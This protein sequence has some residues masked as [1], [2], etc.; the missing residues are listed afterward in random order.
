[1]RPRAWN[2]STAPFPILQPGQ[3]FLGRSHRRRRRGRGQGAA[4]MQADEGQ[5]HDHCRP[6]R[7]CRLHRL[8]SRNSNSR[9]LIFLRSSE[10]LG[11][12]SSVARR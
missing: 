5:Q 11:F 2:D 1:M 4:A 6:D 12:S 9:L 3:E 8:R 10:G 7:A